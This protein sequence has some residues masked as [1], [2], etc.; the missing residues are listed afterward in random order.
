MAYAI[1]DLF[2]AV[3]KPETFIE[4]YLV[5]PVRRCN[6][7]LDFGFAGKY[8]VTKQAKKLQ[9]AIGIL[10][11][12]AMLQ[13]LISEGNVIVGEAVCFLK[14]E[15]ANTERHLCLVRVFRKAPDG[16]WDDS[17]SHMFVDSS[18]VEAMVAYVQDECGRLFV[19]LVRV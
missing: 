11:T 9:T 12:K 16:W 5:P 15:Q 18:M 19:D 14:A 4:V 8:V 17:E 7:E 1:T 6:E 2:T 3:M 10:K 13:C